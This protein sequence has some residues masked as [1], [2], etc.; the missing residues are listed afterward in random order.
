MRLHTF[1]PGRCSSWQLSA[2]LSS[3]SPTLSEIGLFHVPFQHL[4]W[5]SS[6]W[7]PAPELPC[8]GVKCLFVCATYKGE[9]WCILAQQSGEDSLS[10]DALLVLKHIAVHKAIQHSGVGM[11]INVELQ[12]HPLMEEKGME[13]EEITGTERQTHVKQRLGEKDRT[14]WWHS[15]QQST[16]QILHWG[17]KTICPCSPEIVLESSSHPREDYTPPHYC[18]LRTYLYLKEPSTHTTLITPSFWRARLEN[19]HAQWS[20]PTHTHTPMSHTH[21]KFIY[22]I[23]IDFILSV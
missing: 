17:K 9:V 7:H 21:H 14:F 16:P 4:L 1:T 20:S 5:D 12:T 8:A 19:I 22:E 11:N 10:L 18:K 13:G 15:E 23:N 3:T 6:S 2:W